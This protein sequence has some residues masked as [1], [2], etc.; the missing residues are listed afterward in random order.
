MNTAARYR[1]IGRLLLTGAVGVLVP[2]TLLSIKF[3]Y[4]DILRQDAGEVLAQFRLG[5]SALVFTWFAFAWL[6]IPLLVAYM[7]IGEVL[8]G[9]FVWERVITTMGVISGIVQIVAL[10]RWTF[11]VPV[12]AERYT[13]AD[14]AMK[15]TIVM[16][17]DIVN[18]AGGVLLGEHVG[19]LLTIVWMVGVANALCQQ[20]LITPWLKYFAYAAGAV[21]LMAQGE[22]LATVVPRFVIWAEAGF[23]GSTL[24]LLWM[25]AVGVSFL[26]HRTKV[27]LVDRREKPINSRLQKTNS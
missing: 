20:Q 14:E 5:G 16:I 1:W 22:L 9:K 18:Q 27:M 4:P 8:K 15:K 24:W 19:Q 17:F 6:G 12:L 11:V 13:H 26:R 25:M 23:M 3:N 2:Y 7:M 10:L 21:Y